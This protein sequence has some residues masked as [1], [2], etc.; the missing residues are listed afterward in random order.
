M[1]GMANHCVLRMVWHGRIDRQKE[2]EDWSGM[3][4]WLYRKLAACGTAC[5]HG[6]W[7]DIFEWHIFEYLR[8]CGMVWRLY[9]HGK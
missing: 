4:S 1:D 7:K 6:G 3:A 2:I 8:L 5:H 9:D